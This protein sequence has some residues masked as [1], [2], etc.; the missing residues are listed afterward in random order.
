[1][2]CNRKTRQKG[3]RDRVFKTEVLKMLVGSKKAL[4]IIVLDLKCKCAH[5]K[6]TC[7]SMYTYICIFNLFTRSPRSFSAKLLSLQKCTACSAV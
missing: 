4:K 7:I 2:Q 1:M 3:E 5:F 6:H